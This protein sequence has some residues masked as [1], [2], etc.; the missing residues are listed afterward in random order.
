M[1]IDAM[2]SFSKEMVL[3]KFLMRYSDYLAPLVV[4]VLKMIGC[5]TKTYFFFNK[6]QSNEVDFDEKFSFP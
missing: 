5:N 6:R 4:S 3:F 2:I 1:S